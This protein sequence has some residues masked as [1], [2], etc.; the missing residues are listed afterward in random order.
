VYEAAIQE[1]ASLNILH[2]C[3]ENIMLDLLSDYPVQVIN[4]EATSPRNPSLR[5]AFERTNKALWGG[6]DHK[7]TLLKGPVDKIVAEVHDALDQ[8]GGRRFILG[9]GC[10]S[11]SQV[12]EAHWI[13]A[14]EALST[15]RRG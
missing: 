3:R 5:E 12:P 10:T 4:Y 11:V 8:T 9:N 2:I 14:K 13:A 7:T 6:L 15:W 1:G